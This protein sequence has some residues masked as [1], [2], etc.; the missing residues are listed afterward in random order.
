M[1][2]SIWP[3]IPSKF[4]SSMLAGHSALGLAFAALM[5]VLCISGTLLDLHGPSKGFYFRF[6]GFIFIGLLSPTVGPQAVD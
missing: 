2:K 5:Y 1:S 3:K 4:V 6:W